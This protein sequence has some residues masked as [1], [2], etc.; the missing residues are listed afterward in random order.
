MII[1]IVLHS[2]T[3]CFASYLI[4][5]INPMLSCNWYHQQKKEKKI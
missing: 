2:V 5:S 4:I 1:T 3:F